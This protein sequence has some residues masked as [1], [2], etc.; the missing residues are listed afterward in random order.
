M[1]NKKNSGFT[2]IELLVVIA[3]IGILAALV[4]VALG[5]A[6]DKAQDAR[7]KSSIGQLRTL[8][9]VVYDNDGSTYAYIASCF[10]ASGTAALT[11]CGS[12]TVVTSVTSLRTDLTGAGST[13]S[14]GV[15][16]AAGYCVS[17][18]LKSDP[19]KSF[20]QDSSGK[21]GTTACA[22]AACP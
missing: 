8:G 16:T 4:L 22:A 12:A 13:L 6:R 10:G 17:A 20:C 11:S 2:L 18:T 15:P 7:I 3:I 5:N 21:T 19:S 1:N 9:E 14:L